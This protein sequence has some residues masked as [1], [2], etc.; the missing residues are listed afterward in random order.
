VLVSQSEERDAREEACRRARG[1]R[2]EAGLDNLIES[3]EADS[4][5]VAKRL[6]RLKDWLVNTP[7]PR[8]PCHRV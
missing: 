3:Y 1:D 7:P 6:E 5:L 2:D 8:R 4:A